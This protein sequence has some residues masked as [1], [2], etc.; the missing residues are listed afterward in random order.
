MTLKGKMLHL[1]S[2]HTGELTQANCQQVVS[3]KIWRSKH[4][5]HPATHEI[6]VSNYQDAFLQHLKAPLE[7]VSSKIYKSSPSERLL[8]E[9]FIA[10]KNF[11]SFMTAAYLTGKTCLQ[12]FAWISC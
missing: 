12:R 4:A 1:F 11:G 7:T 2:N 6:S 8:V 5:Q 9:N 3:L 10:K